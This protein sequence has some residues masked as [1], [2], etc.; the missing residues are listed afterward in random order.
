MNPIMMEIN[1]SYLAFLEGLNEVDKAQLL[2]GNWDARPQGANFWMRQW[3]KPI[4][5]NEVPRNIIT[6]RAYDLAATE[7]SQA[8]PFPD[9]SACIQMAKDS[10]GYS[11]SSRTGKQGFCHRSNT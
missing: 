2:Y 1:P 6:C 9:P 4:Y 10:N 5:L 8:V 11:G 3:V 7:R